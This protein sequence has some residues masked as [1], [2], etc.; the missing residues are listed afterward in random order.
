MSVNQ[1]IYEVIEK[2]IFLGKYLLQNYSEKL[3]FFEK[4]YK[5]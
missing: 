2:E 5:I 4:K 1:V 3:K